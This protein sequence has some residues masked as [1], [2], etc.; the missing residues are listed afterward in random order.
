[1]KIP[2]THIMKY[3]EMTYL[4]YHLMR[5]YI[6][7]NMSYTMVHILT[8]SFVSLKLNTGLIEY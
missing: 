2:L 1:M 5:N 3:V 7:S 6:Q 8:A 4:S